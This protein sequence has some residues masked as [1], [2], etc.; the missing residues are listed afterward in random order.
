M[1]R[2][3]VV[4]ER[5]ESD[6]ARAATPPAIRT[7]AG[8]RSTC[9]PR[10]T[11]RPDAPLSRWSTCCSGF[12]GR[13]RMLLND[14]PWSPSLD[15]RIGRDHRPRRRGDDP[16]HAR[17]LHALRRIAVHQLDGDRALS[18]PSVH[19]LVP[20]VDRTLP[21]AG[22]TRAS[23]RRRQVVRRLRRAD[24]RHAARGR[25][26]RRRQPQR[27]RAA[28]TT[29]TAA[30]CPKFC[31]DRPERRRPREVVRGSSRPEAQKKSR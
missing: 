8:S 9:R 17:L 11:R 6:G 4:I 24:P 18:G 10:T 13:G 28:S 27:R 20:H 26:R 7:C 15:D 1:K 21:H 3:R 31:A 22:V 5:F 14:N 2:G 19:E 12:T 23:R 30:T 16:R 25:L 29:A